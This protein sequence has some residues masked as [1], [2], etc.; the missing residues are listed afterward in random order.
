MAGRLAF[1]AVALVLMI[2][3][4]GCAPVLLAT[5]AAGGGGTILWMKGKLEENLDAPFDR[6]HT[7]TIGGLRSL[8]LPINKDR[9]DRV[10]AEIETEFSD[11]KK[12]SIKL[13]SLSESITKITV[14]VGTFGDEDRSKR[15]LEA[16]HK[17]L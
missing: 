8:A 4:S 12:I 7:A 1:L 6:A 3:I 17:N 5:G 11:G 2:Q 16:I 9:K 10:T 15:I 14:R 13:K